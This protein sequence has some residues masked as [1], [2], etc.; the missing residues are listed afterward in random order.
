MFEKLSEFQVVILSLVVAVVLSALAGV[1]LKVIGIDSAILY[2]FVGASIG[3]ICMTIG[4][5]LY[6]KAKLK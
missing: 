4:M 6:E 5:G 3:S 2:V 1:G